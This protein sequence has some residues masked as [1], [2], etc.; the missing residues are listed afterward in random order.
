MDIKDLER[1]LRR[2]LKAVEDRQSNHVFYWATIQG[3][4]FRVAKFSHSGRGQLAD[5][6]VSDTAK[7]L[8]LSKTE[9]NK[10]VDC[11]LSGRQFRELWE[12][13]EMQFG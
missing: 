6:I 4:D 5:F 12:C 2:K 13:R 8:K 10:L 7:R 3:R 9:L 1:S 11:S